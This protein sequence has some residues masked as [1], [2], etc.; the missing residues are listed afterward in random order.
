L[1]KIGILL[2]LLRGF[3]WIRGHL[4]GE[5]HGEGGVLGEWCDDGVGWKWIS[6]KEEKKFGVR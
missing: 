3:Y 1:L 6:L 4:V 2:F 5:R